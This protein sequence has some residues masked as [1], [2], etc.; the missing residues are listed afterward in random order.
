MLTLILLNQT[1]TATSLERH[2]RLNSKIQTQDLFIPSK[3]SKIDKQVKFFEISKELAELNSKLHLM[4][5]IETNLTGQIQLTISKLYSDFVDRKNGFCNTFY[6]TNEGLK[7]KIDYTEFHGNEC[8]AFIKEFTQ[9]KLDTQSLTEEPKFIDYDT[10][11]FTNDILL[12]TFLDIKD[13]ALYHY[14]RRNRINVQYASLLVS[15]KEDT[16]IR[17]FSEGLNSKLTLAHEIDCHSLK[18]SNPKKHGTR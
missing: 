6:R 13:Q 4:P 2:V 1:T 17:Y 14:L 12:M 16:V 3:L 9:K 8:L 18:L 10:H 15:H 7:C 5:R 11:T